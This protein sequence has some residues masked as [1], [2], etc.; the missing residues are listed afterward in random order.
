M[1]RDGVKQRGVSAFVPGFLPANELSL[2]DDTGLCLWKIVLA[3]NLASKRQKTSHGPLL[4]DCHTWP[5]EETN[6]GPLVVSLQPSRSK[7]VSVHL[8][9]ASFLQMSFL[10]LMILDSALGTL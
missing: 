1:E 5:L 6:Y 2:P 4:I 7:E 3:N 9:L 10:Y 8:C